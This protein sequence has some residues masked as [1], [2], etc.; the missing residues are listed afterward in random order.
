[1]RCLLLL[2]ALPLWAADDADAI[3]Q[4]LVKAQEKNDQLATQYTYTEQLERFS[5][6]RAGQPHSTGSETHDVIFVEGLRYEK[7]VERN[8]Q[9][10]SA[11][12]QAQVEKQMQQ[13]AAERRRMGHAVSPGGAVVV[14]GF[15]SHKTTD[16]GSL[17]EL[18]MFF[19]NRV[20]GEEEIRGH[21]TW[22]IECQPEKLPG[23][24]S[25]HERQVQSLRKKLWI[26]R[27]DGV[28][29]R[30]EYLFVAPDNI[31][32][33]GSSL[34]FDYE[35]IDANVW[36]PVAM[37]VDASNSRDKVFKP[38]ERLVYRM[39]HFQKFDVQSTITVK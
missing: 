33:P 28:L 32:S 30:A 19:A 27:Q 2:L 35:K 34:T 11:K 38:G 5:F 9:P 15:L 21:K 16:L 17:S 31:L 18:L 25:P 29:V 10:L 24:P 7:L 22:V 26:D 36:E 23:Q 6:D 14:H 3:L 1:M 20:A 37:T 8:G 4:R 12:E 39:D 13:T